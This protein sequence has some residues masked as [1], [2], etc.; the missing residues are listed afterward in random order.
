MYTS[1]EI[2]TR[3]D[4]NQAL[5]RAINNNELLTLRT[6]SSP[7]SADAD[8][9]ILSYA[10]SG[11]VVE[12]IID[13]Y[14]AEAMSELLNALSEGALYDE[15][16]EQVLGLNSDDLDNAFRESIGLPPLPKTL[17]S[18]A[19][20][21]MEEPAESA[22][23]TETPEPTEAVVE[24]SP[25]EPQEVA[26]STEI[27]TEEATEPT[28]IPVQPAAETGAENEN[29]PFGLQC[30][31][32]GVVPFVLLGLVFYLSRFMFGGLR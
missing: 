4:F 8:E 27:T 15:A 5:N 13:T 1:G 21:D 28:P 9:A 29:S 12:F 22:T 2:Y 26:E 6:L 7:F 20:A 16:L 30:C 10:Q 25:D 18:V 11:A 17:N 19:A 23:I 24:E 32:A 3:P 31:L 14:G